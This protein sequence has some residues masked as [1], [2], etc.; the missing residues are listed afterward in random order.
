MSCPFYH[1]ATMIMNSNRPQS[2]Y[3]I[4]SHRP[5]FACSLS[6]PL[7]S[8]GNMALTPSPEDID[9]LPYHAL[10][11]EAAKHSIRRNLGIAKLREALKLILG[12]D[13]DP[14]K[15]PAQWYIASAKRGAAPTQSKAAA[16][17]R[18][19]KTNARLNAAKT[20]AAQAPPPPPS[21][22]T[23]RARR[24]RNPPNP[25]SHPSSSSRAS[26]VS[27]RR[28]A[29]PSSPATGNPADRAS[30]AARSHSPSPSRR[31]VPASPNRSGAHASTS[32]TQQTSSDRTG[33]TTAIFLK[34]VR[35]EAQ[36]RGI[37]PPRHQYNPDP[38]AVRPTSLDLPDAIR[39]EA[40]RLGLN[41]CDHPNNIDFLCFLIRDTLKEINAGNYIAA[42][43][44]ASHKPIKYLPRLP[45]VSPT[46]PVDT[47]H[48][49]NYGLASSPVNPTASWPT[50]D[51]PQRSGRTDTSSRSR[52]SPSL[53]RL[54]VS[55]VQVS[56]PPDGSFNAPSI[57][58]PDLPALPQTQ[59]RFP[60]RRG[61]LDDLSE[62]S[63]DEPQSRSQVEALLGSDPALIP[64]T[65]PTSRKRRQGEDDLGNASTTPT[66]TPP[67]NKKA[68]L[69]QSPIASSSRPSGGNYRSPVADSDE[70]MSPPPQILRPLRIFSSARRTPVVPPDSPSPAPSPVAGPSQ[71]TLYGTESHYI[72]DSTTRFSELLRGHTRLLPSPPPKSNPSSQ[73]R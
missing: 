73:H 25:S 54:N 37:I 36:V 2:I 8:I 46:N 65:Q 34:A 61:R 18:P 44:Q 10:Q 28:P 70:S 19:T 7:K 50:G 60:G 1:P 58:S 71:P 45:P 17:P 41:N 40:K 26:T 72:D 63:D 31:S 22:K 3:L 12:S 66:T 27:P 62:S 5:R 48:Y 59:R 42:M 4:P 30:P 20:K 67:A 23:S 53:T 56:T 55:T 14:D 38:A 47:T 29:H 68:R 13:P 35:D 6:R 57:D 51:S 9:S 43:L 49:N 11:A 64:A 39:R 32:R 69:T 24:S 15:I 21:P 16:V 52:V 33:E